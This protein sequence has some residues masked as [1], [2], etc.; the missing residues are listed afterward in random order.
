M[1]IN[2][3]EIKDLVTIAK[4]FIDPLISTLIK[5]KID[6]LSK[7]LK[8]QEI[9]NGVIDNHFENKFEEFIARTYDRCQNINVL[10]FQNQQVKISEIY[11]PL[12]IQSSKDSAS[13]RIESKNFDFIKAY[14]KILISDSAGMGK[15][16][17]MKW[18]GTRLI[19]TNHSI[20]ILVE[21]RNLKE[22]NTV[23]DEIHI[24]INPIDKSFDKDLILKFLELGQFTILLDGFDEIQLKNQE[25]II[26]DLR[27]FI[28]KAPLN[29]FILTSRPEGAL[30]SFGDFQLFNIV[31]LKDKEAFEL[32]N[33]YD[34]ICP[35]KIA[36]KLVRDIKANFNQTKEL[37][38]NPFLVSLIYSTYAYSK[39][40]PSKKVTFYEEI[41]SAL[42]KRHDL[43]KDGWTR[44]KKSKLDIQLFKIILRQLAFDTSIVGT[45][46][47][48]ESEILEY[49]NKAKGKCP[50]VDF[51]TTDF[52]D[53]LLSA[54]PLFQ[55]DGSK[56]KWAHKSLQDYF[57]AEF[58]AFV[59]KKD[60][61][62]ERIYKS[63][64]DGFLNILELFFE[65]DYKT[66]RKI[67]VKALLEDYVKY[68][69]S[70]YK[71]IT[72]I[73]EELIA[74]R[75]AKTFEVEAVIA[76]HRSTKTKAI[77]EDLKNL[78]KFTREIKWKD[79]KPMIFALHNVMVITTYSFKRR[80]I[81]FLATKELA[82]IS[83]KYNRQAG[84]VVSLSIGP[85]EI[86]QINDKANSIVNKKT[87]FK[88]VNDLLS[89]VVQIHGGNALVVLDF[90][91]ATKELAQINMDI[92]EENK[93]DNFKDI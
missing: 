34:S 64:R 53:D 87:N 29:N 4:P 14:K 40:I 91:E 36:D 80:L 35:A 18:L 66:F 56:I 27:D 51:Q 50:G 83:T 24:Q 75:K 85:D 28:G 65:L 41:Y 78:E 22:T 1:D 45:I 17:V 52:L 21:L 84:D 70:S 47:Y 54:V 93:A 43:S 63:E 73:N 58:I 9:T 61:I 15:S 13:Y 86:W 16:T 88:K 25:L 30:A 10:I 3:T 49:I 38:G 57:A 92:R 60:E 48:S 59:S 79:K 20:P 71:Y 89:F 90:S 5:P 39:D 33:K 23:L 67:I 68:F 26:K 82:Y 46:V 31:P 74:E 2:M 37:L 69:K 7:W 62:I 8:K 42:Y 76:S 32:I 77:F 6:Q 19:Q 44:Q 11:Y 81:E 55:R 12:T 72:G